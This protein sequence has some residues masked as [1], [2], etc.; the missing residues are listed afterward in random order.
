M[1]RL[2][3]I[4]DSIIGGSVGGLKTNAEKKKQESNKR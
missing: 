1:A 2:D 4:C 3:G